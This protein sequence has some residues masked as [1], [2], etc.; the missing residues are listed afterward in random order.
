MKYVIET[1]TFITGW[2]NT[3]TDDE[4]YPLVF[5]SKEQAENALADYLNDAQEAFVRGD[6]KHS[7][8]SEDYRISEVTK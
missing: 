4:G 1:D 8:L 6:I 2:A 3:W 7:C 5:D